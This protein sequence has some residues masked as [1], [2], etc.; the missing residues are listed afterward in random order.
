VTAF[1]EVLDEAA[2]KATLY[3]IE[4]LVEERGLSR[5][6]AYLLTRY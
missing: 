2:K 1:T 4:Y 5:E 3:M 6:D